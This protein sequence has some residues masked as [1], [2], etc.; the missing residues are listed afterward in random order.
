MKNYNLIRF[1]KVLM[2][3]P[4]LLFLVNCS[5]SSK[6]SNSN[7]NQCYSQNNQGQYGNG[8]TYYN[9]NCNNAGNGQYGQSQ[10][11]QGIY[12]YQGQPVRCDYP[13]QCS[14]WTLQMNSNGPYGALGTEGQSVRC[15]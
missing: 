8:S 13:Q 2:L 10:S 15:I 12:F 14:G 9:P 1:A 5:K 7:N 11:C 3:L 6:D 4:C